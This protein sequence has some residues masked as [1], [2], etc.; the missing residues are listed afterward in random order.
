M[1]INVFI[2][3]TFKHLH[4][5][6]KPHLRL[7]KNIY[8]VEKLLYFSTVFCKGA[9]PFPKPVSK[10]DHRHTNTMKVFV[11]KLRKRHKKLSSDLRNNRVLLPPK[12]RKKNFVQFYF[13]RQGVRNKRKKGLKLFVTIALCCKG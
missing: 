9:T 12:K 11:Q 3:F 5:N 7:D 2:C 13:W 10:T 1:Q 6:L 4:F 8:F